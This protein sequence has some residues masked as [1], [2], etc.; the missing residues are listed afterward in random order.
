MDIQKVGTEHIAERRMQR[1]SRKVEPYGSMRALDDASTLNS[2]ADAAKVAEMEEQLHNKPCYIIHPE[3]GLMSMWDSVTALALVFTAMVTPFEVG[4]LPSAESWRDALFLINR[5]LDCI[6]VVD[7]VVSSLLM[8][9]VPQKPNQEKKLELQSPRHRN[10]KT[11]AERL[12]RRATVAEMSGLD[13]S[14]DQ[15]PTAALAWEYRYRHVL[16]NYLTGWFLIDVLSVGPSAFDI[17]DLATKPETVANATA[18]LLELGSG[19]ALGSSNR[20][21]LLDQAADESNIKVVKVLRVIRTLRLFKLLRLMRGSKIVKRWATRISMPYATIAITQLLLMV[22]YVIHFSA[23]MLGV[24]AT[25]SEPNPKLD[26]WQGYYGYCGRGSKPAGARGKPLNVLIY[27]L[28]DGSGTFTCVGPFEI[29]LASL[30]WALSIIVTGGGDP[31]AGPYPGNESADPMSYLLGETIS[32]TVLIIAMAAL[33]SY[34][35]AKF[36]DVISS[37]NPD[38]TLSRNQIDDL[39]RF[40]TYYHLPDTLRRKLREYAHERKEVN[41][42]VMSPWLH[43]VH[44]NARCHNAPTHTLI[45]LQVTNR[46][47][48]RYC[49]PISGSGSSP[50][51]RTS[52]RRGWR[53]SSTATGSRASRCCIGCRQSSSCEWH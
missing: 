51:S 21:T 46:S 10:S 15:K 33:W 43:P 36:V 45:L 39:N 7:M 1:R 44:Q 5:L 19:D 29:W 17:Y 48:N 32:L 37:S 53:G 24:M 52:S 12:K 9:R 23:C 2:L 18:N 47:P 41:E 28:L 38:A 22:L 14:I 20:T 34:V 4:F 27:D 3:A 50:T 40:C 42:R 13:E 30:G 8:Y 11:R 49:S 31:Q 25:F 35:T 6:F 26:S 16:C